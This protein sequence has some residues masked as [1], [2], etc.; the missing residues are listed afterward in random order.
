MS[1]RRTG[2]RGG[3]CGASTRSSDARRVERTR[4]KKSDDRGGVANQGQ[5][6]KFWL[7]T[8]NL[9]ISHFL[10]ADCCVDSLGE[11]DHAAHLQVSQR[12]HQH[13][14]RRNRRRGLPRTGD[15]GRRETGS[16]FQ[17]HRECYC[18]TVMVSRAKS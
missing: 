5:G 3:R 9:I 16:F 11:R 17:H 15:H 10:F 1:E 2:R 4:P 8:L 6:H 14:R 13:R 7:L 12:L 18:I